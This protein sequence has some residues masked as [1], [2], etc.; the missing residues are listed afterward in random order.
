ME[1]SQVF[2][3]I[4]RNIEDSQLN[5]PMS[6][7]AFSIKSSFLKRFSE[8]SQNSEI[9]KWPRTNAQVD[10]K[11]NLLKEETLKLKHDKVIGDLER[12]KQVYDKEK[13][14]L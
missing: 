14:K 5:Y 7:T 10:N 8:D 6:R 4:I 3:S 11:I 2:N 1:A 12:L 13:I 9:R